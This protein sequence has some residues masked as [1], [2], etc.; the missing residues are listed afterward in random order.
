MSD[1]AV[2]T[3]DADCLLQMDTE[4]KQTG[5]GAQCKLECADFMISEVFSLTSGPSLPVM[6]EAFVQNDITTSEM[7]YINVKSE[8]SDDQTRDDAECT[9]KDEVSVAG[10]TSSPVC[11]LCIEQEQFCGQA[12]KDVVSVELSYLEVKTE[13]PDA[14]HPEYPTKTS[15]PIH[16]P[17]ATECKLEAPE[18]VAGYSDPNT[19]SP[20][21]LESL[22]LHN[23]SSAQQYKKRIDEKF[24]NGP[25]EQANKKLYCCLECGKDFKRLDVLKSHQQIHTG[26]KP[27]HCPLC[28]KYF[29]HRGTLRKHQ[30]LHTGEKPYCCSQC[31]QDFSSLDN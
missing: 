31:G 16:Y 22:E 25:Q 24:Y 23:G 19:Q 10:G 28:G 26:E 1:W 13:G 21:P 29:R 12:N 11:E 30:R 15:R 5:S 27:Y 4:A 8:R 17:S 9:L 2:K 14:K 6:A 7:T 3:A 18:M 20:K